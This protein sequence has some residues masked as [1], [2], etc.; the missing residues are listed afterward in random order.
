MVDNAVVTVW[1]N[2]RYVHARMDSRDQ[3]ANMVSTTYLNL[4]FSG[5][6]NL[7]YMVYGKRTTSYVCV[8][9]YLTIFFSGSQNLPYMVYGKRTTSYVCVLP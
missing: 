4:P 6:Q 2:S 3:D 7:P 8:F 5:S 1:V 9:P